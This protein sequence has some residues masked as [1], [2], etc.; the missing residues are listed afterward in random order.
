MFKYGKMQKKVSSRLLCDSHDA[1]LDSM[2]PGVHVTAA[3]DFFCV[4][5]IYVIVKIMTP[6]FNRLSPL[7]RSPVG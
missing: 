6:C 3:L 7:S 5:V 2:L 1:C 4:Q